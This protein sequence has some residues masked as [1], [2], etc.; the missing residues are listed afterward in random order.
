[1]AKKRATR[2]GDNIP[3]VPLDRLADVGQ[4]DEILREA[5]GGT[6]TQVREVV[7]RVQSGWPGLS[8]DEIYAR[9]CHLKNGNRRHRWRHV[10]WREE[11]I[12][13][14]RTH[15]GQGLAAARQTVKELGIRR[16]ELT[17]DRIH[18][19]AGKLG[20][21]NQSGPRKRWEKSED[22]LLRWQ[23]G[24]KDIPFFVRKLERTPAAIRQHFSRLGLSAAVR[25]PTYLTPYRVSKMLGVS[26]SIVRVWVE[27]DL[28]TPYGNVKRNGS[29]RSKVL[30][31]KQALFAFCLD[32]A[33]KVNLARCHDDV[34]DWLDENKKT[35]RQPWNGHRQH[36]TKQ[37][38]CPRC[39]RLI[40]GNAFARH[41]KSCGGHLPFQR[42]EEM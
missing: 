2:G 40:I 23:G 3:R 27:K 20:R 24:M 30:I 38:E 25:E 6:P 37:K 4:I 17:G 9:F 5:I 11:D 26:D 29:G 18:R 33:D 12:E 14:V 36:V 35:P 15:Y 41:V 31:H 32:N 22:K 34:R 16:P 39:G 21:T 19:M 13:F 10:E 1:M 8:H 42:S 28:F 7:R